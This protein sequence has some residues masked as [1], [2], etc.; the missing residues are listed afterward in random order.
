MEASSF[1]QPKINQ[2]NV[3]AT[4]A[5]PRDIYNIV[6]DLRIKRTPDQKTRALVSLQCGVTV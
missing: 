5:K 6:Q 3:L 1:K 2:F 4:L